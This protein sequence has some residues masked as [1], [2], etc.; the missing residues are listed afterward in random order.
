MESTFGFR[1]IPLTTAKVSSQSNLDH[2]FVC[3][4]ATPHVTR[5]AD[6]VVGTMTTTVCLTCGLLLLLCEA[7]AAYPLAV[8]GLTLEEEVDASP[9]LTAVGLTRKRSRSTS[10]NQDLVSLA[11]M[12]AKHEQLRRVQQAQ[13]FLHSIGKRDVM[14]G[15][16]VIGNQAA[17]SVDYLP[18]SAPYAHTDMT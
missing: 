2:Y 1:R 17:M 7:A 10:I 16:D 9:W 6:L 14:G 15:R 11:D 3:A 4:L 12:L 13:S 5:S 8:R 18:A